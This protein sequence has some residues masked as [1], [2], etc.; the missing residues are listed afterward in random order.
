MASKAQTGANVTST[1]KFCCFQS[2]N[3]LF[4]LTG[5]SRGRKGQPWE[6]IALSSAFESGSLHVSAVNMQ[7]VSG[8]P[9]F[10]EGICQPCQLPCGMPASPAASL[11]SKTRSC[12]DPT[13]AMGHLERQPYLA[14]MPTAPASPASWPPP[15]LIPVEAPGACSR[16]WFSQSCI[17]RDQSPALSISQP[18]PRESKK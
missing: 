10:A 11:T 2:L 8:M 18:P 16:L 4:K 3:G 9:G 7:V 17:A 6:T 14:P 1:S 12:F 15:G 13:G 5:F